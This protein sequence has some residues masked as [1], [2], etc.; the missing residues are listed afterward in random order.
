MVNKAKIKEIFSSIQGEGLYIGTQQL[1]VRFCACNLRCD[2]CDTAFLP[3]DINDKKSY[4]EFTPQELV[5]YINTNYD[6]S[7]ISFISLTGGEPLIWGDFLAEF[8]PL[9]KAKF[10]LETNA[11]IVDNLDRILPYIEVISADI[12][13][14]SCSGVHNSFELH[15]SFFH[16]IKNYKV[17]CAVTRQY[18]CD[19]KKIFAKIVFDDNITDYE[20]EKS[21]QLAQKYGLEVILQPR[22]LGEDTYIDVPMVLDVFNRFR[23]KYSNVRLIPQ[24]HKFLKIE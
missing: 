9:L 10:Y 20:I 24:V 14:P 16:K 21:M 5:E 18:D 23:Q 12:K 17:D 11:T 15:D 19:G 6:L 2:Y 8:L 7:T 4:F 3:T 22:M 13:L 1:F